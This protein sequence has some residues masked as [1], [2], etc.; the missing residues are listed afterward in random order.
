MAAHEG[1][2]HLVALIHVG[3]RVAAAEAVAV[4]DGFHQA[5]DVEETDLVF[6]E[7]LDGFFVGAIGGAGAKAALLDGLLQAARQRKVSSSAT[8][9]VSILRVVKSSSGTTPGTRA[10]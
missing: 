8:S 4:H 7:E 3:Q 2:G 6:E 9:K 10:G 1:A 5:A